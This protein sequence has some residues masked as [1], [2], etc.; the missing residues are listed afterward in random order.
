MCLSACGSLPS[1]GGQIELIPVKSSIFQIVERNF[2]QIK[3]QLNRNYF[4]MFLIKYFSKKQSVN[5]LK[6]NN[7][8][9]GT[10]SLQ[11]NPISIAKFNHICL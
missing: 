7:E 6:S 11:G 4:L 3:Y 9:F 10:P 5:I 8:Q 2:F 1:R